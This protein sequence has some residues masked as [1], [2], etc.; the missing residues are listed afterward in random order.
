VNF[1]KWIGVF[2]FIV[3]VY[4]L[5]QIKLVL[6]LF[7][8]SVVLATSLNRLVRQFQKQN[9]KRGWAIALSLGILLLLS[10]LF[11]LVI[12]P[13]FIDQVK[14][15][16]LLIPTAIN[17][18]REWELWLEGRLPESVLRSIQ[19]LE[20]IPRE[21]QSF[22][23]QLI[24]NFF[25]LFSSSLRILLHFLAIFVVGLMLLANPQPYRDAFISLF[26]SFY[27]RR[28]DEILDKCEVA[29]GGWVT[30]ILFNMFVIA[31]LSGL[32]LWILNIPLA[33]ANAMLAG[34]LTFIPHIGPAL[35]V[36]PPIILALLEAPWKAVAVLVLY[37]VVQQIESNILTPLVMQKQVS[38][39]PAFT[40]LSQFTFAIFFEILGLF[41][42][43]PIMV[44][45][46]VWLQEV[47]I[48]DVLNR[49][50]R[51][52]REIPLRYL[53]VSPRN[54]SLPHHKLQP[55]QETSIKSNHSNSDTLNL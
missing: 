46:Q 44:V 41:L 52:G 32:G 23:T 19:G 30:G 33:L 24:T 2:A 53:Q 15:L 45:L 16:F 29:L 12:V 21:V 26:P 10:I 43:L 9:I 27:R 47:L 5:W 55:S 42:A 35:S 18:F 8:A 34:I 14:Q 37:I 22:A 6:L 51:K 39:L 13:P 28:A 20:E 48:H 38:L 11:F 25:G 31:V 40:L 4:I 49:W 50:D 3:S 1:G 36:V 17:R 7:F 54:E